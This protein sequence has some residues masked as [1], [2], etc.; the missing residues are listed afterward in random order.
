LVEAATLSAA[1]T[2]L[3]GQGLI[4]TTLA[5]KQNDNWN[6]E[7]LQR[8][9]FGVS[10]KDLFTFT[11][12]FSTMISSGLPVAQALRI[13]S[14]QTSSTYF[15][16][17]LDSI[18]RDVEGGSTLSKAL[19][20]YPRVFS[21][22]YISLVRSGEL[23]GTLDKVLER[24]SAN[25]EKD[26]EFK[27]KV[28]GALIYPVIVITMMIGVMVIILIF[29]IPKLTEMYSSMGVDLPLPT[30][31]MV[32]SSQF[33]VSYWWLAL[34]LL[35]GVVAAFN[36]FKKTPFGRRQLDIISFKIPVFGNLMK[37]SQLAEFTRDLGVLIGSGIPII[38]ALK[39]SREALQNSLLRD[40]IDKAVG[41]VGR[42]QPLSQI[43]AGDPA[44]P[45]II[46]QML[47]VGEETG[48]VDKVLLDVSKYF[49]SETDFAV[50][51]LSTAL[52]PIIMVVLGGGVGLLIL[53]IITPIYKLTSSF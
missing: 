36:Y 51:N 21:V 25:L 32:W 50:K 7:A 8:K 17:V 23:S 35:V 10:S 16:E 42:G 4:I 20:K 52:E 49:E 41:S 28:K 48:R 9:I 24:L 31:I 19:E 34:M 29:V 33:L 15:K 2:L 26:R 39:S 40:T 13:L 6:F 44:F 1:V 18:L 53:S 37:I 46:S 47:T 22:I 3:R 38:D 14:G 43:I 30:K 5:E 12:E 27:G 11:R 45:P